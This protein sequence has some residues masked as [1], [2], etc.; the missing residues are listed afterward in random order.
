MTFSLTTLLLSA[1]TFYGC[2]ECIHESQERKRKKIG[3]I[4]LIGLMGG[5]YGN[6]RG[7]RRDLASCFSVTDESTLLN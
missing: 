3:G 7:G 2:I 6:S 4:K 1:G 5:G